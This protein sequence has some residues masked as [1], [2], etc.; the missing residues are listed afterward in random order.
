MKRLLSLALFLLLFA[1]VTLQGASCAIEK[2]TPGEWISSS[3][4]GEFRF[5]VNPARTQITKYVLLIPITIVDGIDT[6]ND[7]GKFTS[8]VPES[9]DL[10]P[11]TRRGKF[12]INSSGN[13]FDIVVKGSF[14]KTGTHASGTWKII[15][16]DDG[17]TYQSGTW[18]ASAP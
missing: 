7:I 4:I 12:T 16:D 5:T 10:W 11:I 1:V 13:G 3:H 9:L 8:E 14:D 2:P 15:S 6:S 18:E 17:T